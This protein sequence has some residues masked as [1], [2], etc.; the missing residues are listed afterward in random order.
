[1]GA[2]KKILVVDDMYIIRNMVRHTLSKAGYDV[3]MAENGRDA[4]SFFSS[5][6]IPPDLVVCDITMPVL[7]GLE[8]LQELKR[9]D[10]GKNT[11][12]IF[13][14]A[15]GQKASVVKALQMGCNDYAVKPYK[16]EVL[17]K[18]VERL[19]KPC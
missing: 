15:D 5:D 19:L 14:T 12:V 18:K 9:L 1:M 7:N 2:K 16:P 3:F 4:L 8:F 13:L 6:R 10:R 11:P 17:L